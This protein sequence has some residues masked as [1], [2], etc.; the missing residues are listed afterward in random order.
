MAHTGG[1]TTLQ[2]VSRH[3]MLA[4]GLAA[5]FS[6][7]GCQ[8]GS[9]SESSGG[10]TA[11]EL[12]S[13]YS[14]R[15]I[16]ILPFTKPRSFDMSDDLPDGIAVSLRPLD[17]SGDPTKAYGKFN[18]E[19]YSYRKAAGDHRGTLLQTWT[20]PILSPK[21]QKKFWERVTSTYEFRLDWAGSPIPPQEKYVL[22]ASFEAP[23]SKRLFD[24]YEFEFRITREDVINAGKGAAAPK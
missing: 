19:L 11:E 23:G 22:V 6:L 13:Y 3:A 2:E 17:E 1:A 15:A 12:V 24:E 8:R 5:T 7:A 4:F 18:F 20:Q 10:P 9:I 14:P 16:K 21:D